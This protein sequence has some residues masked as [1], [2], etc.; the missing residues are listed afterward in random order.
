MIS[1]FFSRR[2]TVARLRAGPFGQYLDEFARSLWEQGYSP[3]LS[4]QNFMQ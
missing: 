1:H 4:E 2:K 3:I